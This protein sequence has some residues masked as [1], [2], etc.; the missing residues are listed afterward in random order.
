[1][2]FKLGKVFAHCQV[3]V[4]ALACVALQISAAWSGGVI[5]DWQNGHNFRSRLIAGTTP[6]GHSDI[7]PGLPVVGLEIEL[8]KGWKTYWRNP[9]DAGGVPPFVSFEG[10]QNV[11]SAELLYPAPR[12]LADAAGVSIGYKEHVLFPIVVTPAD[13]SRPIS[14][15]VHIEYGV[16]REICIPAE[17]THLIEV[18]AGAATELPA[19]LSS[20][21]ASI[22]LRTLI[23]GAPT[24]A[25]RQDS[26]TSIELELQFPN[27]AAGA[28]LFVEAPEGAYV[29]LPKMLAQSGPDRVR[30]AITLG[31]EKEAAAFKG[32]TL[33]LTIVSKA[34]SVTLPLKVK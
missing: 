33:Q 26:A 25:S 13:A 27:G 7:A 18:P 10:S 15:K 23:S 30:Y 6:A 12:R 32:Q 1:M 11:K 34:T 4:I 14:L 8:A 20:A 29:P 28:D 5:G 24:I 3:L 2:R 21:I 31:N 17:A 19:S 9:G 22:P 16:C